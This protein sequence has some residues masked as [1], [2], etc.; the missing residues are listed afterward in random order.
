ME[1]PLITV[2]VDAT[3]SFKQSVSRNG[4][5]LVRYSERWI[6]GHSC[7]EMYSDKWNVTWH[8]GLIP[9][10]NVLIKPGKQLLENESQSNHAAPSYELQKVTKM[11]DYSFW[12]LAIVLHLLLSAGQ[13]T[14]K[15]KHFPE[16]SQNVFLIILCRASHGR[17]DFWLLQQNF[18]PKNHPLSQS[19]M[20]HGL[21][22]QHPF[23]PAL[24]TQKQ[25]TTLA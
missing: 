20:A 1:K 13:K 18:V 7:N 4:G 24:A 15:A 8:I 3:T 23:L 25:T 12:F 10:Q 17:N 16:F 14:V 11:D 6:K 9:H 22:E 5:M 2:E 21:S 19:P